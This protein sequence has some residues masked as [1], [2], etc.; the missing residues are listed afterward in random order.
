[1][2]YLRAIFNESMRLYPQLPE[3]GR[4]AL[5]DKVLP[6]GGG[7]DGKSPAFVPKGKVLMWGTYALHRRPE[8]F[9]EDAAVFNPDWWLDNPNQK[10]VRPGWGFLAFGGGPRVCIGRRSLF[11]SSKNL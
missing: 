6:L 5:E 10:A 7:L 3:N 8:I 9:G 4:V 11:H 1:M 2:P